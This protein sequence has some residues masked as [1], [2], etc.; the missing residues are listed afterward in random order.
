MSFSSA[1]RLLLAYAMGLS[2]IACGGMSEGHRPVADG[3]AVAAGDCAAPQVWFLDLDGDQFGDDYVRVTACQAPAGYVERGGDCNDY[4]PL[5]RPGGSGDPGFVFDRCGQGQPVE[6]MNAKAEWTPLFSSQAGGSGSMVEESGGCSGNRLAFTYDLPEPSA[7]GDASCAW[8]AMRKTPATPLDVSGSDY[9]LVPFHGDPNDPGLQVE[10]SLESEGCRVGW[11]F[12]NASNL[13]ARR[14]AVVPLKWFGTPGPGRGC[15]VDLSKVKAIEI[16]VRLQAPAAD[17]GGRDTGVLHLDAITAVKASDLRVSPSFFACPSTQDFGARGRVVADLLKRHKDSVSQHGHPF[18]ASW[19]EQTPSRYAIYDQA[20]L[21]TVF[22]LEAALWGSS[23]ARDAARA[24]AEG[25]LDLQNRISDGTG[26]W[27]DHYLDQGEGSG[28]VAPAE[29]SLRFGDVAWVVM[30]LDLF[31]DL[32]WPS[33]RQPVDDAIA[34][35]AHWLESG[36]DAYRDTGHT[37]GAIGEGSRDNI[38]TF[39]ALVA[40][41]RFARAAEMKKALLDTVWKADEQRLWRGG[42]DPRL[43]LDVVGS[44]GVEFL[45]AVGE[46]DKALAGLGLAA[47]AFAARSPDGKVAGLGDIAGPGQPSVESTGQYLA[48]GGW[49]SLTL[50]PDLFSHESD[51]SFPGSPG[52]SGGAARAGWH[53]VAPAAWVYLALSPD[54]MAR[55]SL[56]SFADDF[57]REGHWLVSEDGVASRPE[58]AGKGMGSVS[59]STEVTAFAGASLCVVANPGKL[60]ALGSHVTAE[61]QIADTG[62]KGTIRLEADVII[63][64]GGDG[65]VGP[66][67]RLHNQRQVSPGTFAISTLAVRYVANPH[68]PDFGQWGVWSD[69]QPGVAGWTVPSALAYELKPGVLYHIRLIGN[70]DSNRYSDLIITTQDSSIPDRQKAFDLS[71]HA[72]PVEPAQAS[73]EGVWVGLAAESQDNGCGVGAPTE[74]RV[75]YDNLMVRR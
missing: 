37:V 26:H 7:C 40:A 70:F 74:Y 67:L 32:L 58:C 17:I 61:K 28:V 54:V 29:A 50:L 59:R 5:R 21:L 6:A 27:V 47:G 75:C 73:Q 48:T 30:A 8:V 25:L 45:R 43:T 52:D 2:T 14:T 72:I 64:P 15:S 33:P 68:D 56:P 57:E 62:Y 44:W 1:R 60:S 46:H 18:V 71:E 20:L 69:S 42:Q 34:F 65:Q 66:E 4:D 35:G 23:D 51:G 53:G 49:G 39:F 63:P 22:T 12:P 9:L 55:L 10:L 13:P 11:L 31:R 3:G 36:I 24:V 38:S 41:E 16:G 19:F